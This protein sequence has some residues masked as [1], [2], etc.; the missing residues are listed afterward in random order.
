MA[1]DTNGKRYH[2]QKILMAKIYQWQNIRTAKVQMQKIPHVKTYQWQ[3]IP[4]AQYTNCKR[5]QWQNI[6]IAKDIR[7]QWPKLLFQ[8]KSNSKK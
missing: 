1:N 5:Y 2:C 8:K 4:L 3:K 7:Y 6:Q